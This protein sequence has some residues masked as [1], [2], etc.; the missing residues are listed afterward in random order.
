MIIRVNKVD[1]SAAKILPIFLINKE[2][3]GNFKPPFDF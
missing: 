3:G 1:E 2:N